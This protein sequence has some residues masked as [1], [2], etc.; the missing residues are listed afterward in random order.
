MTITIAN[1]K[2]GV[3]KTTTV[4]NL[5]V[6]LALLGK[7]V[8]VIDLDPQAN[9][10]SGLGYANIKDLP[11]NERVNTIY[12]VIIGSCK[13]SE[14]FFAT[15]HENLY[16]MPSSIDLAGAEIELVSMMNREGILDKVLKK[17]HEP[18]DYI[19][20]DCPPSLGLLTINALNASDKVI[21]PVQCEYYALEGIEQLT[22][23]IKLVKDNLNS[24]LEI[25]GVVMT[26]FD[27]RAK[28]SKSVVEEV[29]KTFKNKVFATI[30]PRNIRLS[31]SPSHGL[32]IQEYDNKSNGAKAYNQLAEEFLAKV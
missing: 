16:L 7:K 2:G 11:E 20:I 27:S 25:G 32:S 1:Q 4:L 30:I 29:Q 21:I 3:G 31:E 9:L 12:D 6:A 17:L 18:F 22:E 10:T 28:L 13:S 24:Q 23:T 5:S 8:L 19:L 26:M 15:R 14:A